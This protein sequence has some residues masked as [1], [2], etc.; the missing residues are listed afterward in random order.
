MKKASKTLSALILSFCFFL[1]SNSTL[2]QSWGI[3][4]SLNLLPSNPTTTSIVQIICKSHFAYASCAL[5]N[6]T[7]NVNNNIIT[8]N[9]SHMQ[10]GFSAICYS[11][12]TITL[13]SNFMPGNYTVSFNLLDSNNSVFDID[14]LY[15][16]I[17]QLNGLSEN[18]FEIEAKFQP[19]PFSD[20]SLLT[21]P[22]T[23][24]NQDIEL[25]ILS[26][27]GVLEKFFL[28]Q[29][30]ETLITKGSLRSGIYFYKIKS[31]NQTLATGKFIIN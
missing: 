15:F 21:L 1:N 10:G 7:V 9:A 2:A 4:D 25:L 27:I 23:H 28:I 20:Y 3:I 31:K 8:V 16:T 19:N 24:K 22:F 11:V 26:P 14:T 29:S 17:P 5:I 6:S 13:G 12:D 30:K 18:N